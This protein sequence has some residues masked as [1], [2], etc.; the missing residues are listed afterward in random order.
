MLYRKGAVKGRVPNEIAK[1]T[2]S[3][4][5]DRRIAKATVKVVKAHVEHLCE[6]GVLKNNVCYEILAVLRD[7][8]KNIL[9]NY[10]KEGFEDVHEYIEYYVIEKLGEDLGGFINLGKSRNDQV[11]TAIRLV[12][13]EEIL[14]VLNEIL[15]LQ[16]S[17]L[18]KA[19]ENIE[20]IAL[21]YTHQQKA[22]VTTIAHHLLAYYDALNRDFERIIASLSRVD[23]SPL[24]ASAL[25]GN[26]IPGYD[27]SKVARK[28]GFSKIL[29]NTEDAVASRD[30]I[31]EVMLNLTIL[32]INISRFVED[33]ILWS[34]NEL[35]Y[36]IIPNNHAATSS[37]MPHKRN[38][39]TLEVI[40]AKVA[41]I[42]GYTVA[43]CTLLK[44]LPYSYNLDL[45]ELTPLLWK[46]IDITKESLSI[47]R[48]FI[49]K[50]KFNKER[51]ME[52][53]VRHLAMGFNDLAEYIT[54]T[55]NV[56]FRKVH[57]ILGELSVNEKVNAAKI[58]DTLREKLGIEIS[59]KEILN[60]LN[61]RELILRRKVQGSPNFTEVKRM[62]N[63][64]EIKLYEKKN[65]ITKFQSKT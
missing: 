9:K 23:A 34:M 11:T 24:G 22:Q 18:I 64:R 57:R 19:K 45:Q 7:L 16:H 20:T 12:L 43:A 30:Y 52:S 3:L 4:N 61:F 25:T 65:I 56:P 40:R 26:S 41:E 50:A 48:D 42:L 5:S 15:S 17:L 58:A 46:T 39:V 35:N 49:E 63:E 2:S 38:P 29:E 27:R 32:M 37:I 44:S 21:G 54:L 59:E 47:L 1:F 62:I 8:E 60:M 10:P 36:V 6:I 51:L 31:L 13:K 28:L 55:Y 53:I 14:N 33:L